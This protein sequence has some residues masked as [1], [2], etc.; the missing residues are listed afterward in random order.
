MKKWTNNMGEVVTDEKNYY[1]CIS[2]NEDDFITEGDPISF[3]T[4]L[5]RAKAYAIEQSR[6][7]LA[8]ELRC[9]SMVQDPFYDAPVT[10]WSERY[11]N[12]KKLFRQ[13]WR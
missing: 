11:E 5:E 7:N 9:E 1:V 13:M 4:D 2:N 6:T 12:G 10:H 8:V 3:G